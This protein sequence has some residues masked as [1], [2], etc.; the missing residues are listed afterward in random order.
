MESGPPN[1]VLDLYD[2]LPG[3]GENAVEVRA[4][5][6]D[7]TLRIAYDGPD[8]TEAF[9]V[10]N[11]RGVA[12]FHRANFLTPPLLR[13]SVTPGK[14]LGSLFE[15]PQSDAAK[16]LNENESGGAPIKHYGVWFLSQ[17]QSFQIFAEGV[18]LV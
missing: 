8:D 7:L 12:C 16:L 18:D 2:W 4:A 17:N 14:A 6:A 13:V 11:F 9:R 5:D 3:H 15:F 1:I 10:L